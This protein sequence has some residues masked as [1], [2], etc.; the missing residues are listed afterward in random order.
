MG[1]GLKNK[2][3]IFF[4]LIAILM[5][6]VFFVA[7]SPRPTSD[8]IDT[9]KIQEFRI[10]S[11]DNF[12]RLVR[13]AYIPATLRTSSYL[14]LEVLSDYQKSTGERFA[15]HDELE[16]KFAEVMTSGSLNGVP[17]EKMSG[18]AL[19][20]RLEDI[21]NLSRSTLLINSRFSYSD[22]DVSLYQNNDTGAFQIGVNATI[23]FFAGDTLAKWDK[24][25]TYSIVFNSEDIEDPLYSVG[26][27]NITKDG[28]VYTN[29]FRKTNATVWNLT[30]VFRQIDERLYYHNPKAPSILARFTNQSA[31]S[32]CCGVESFINP[33]AMNHPNITGQTGK[34]FIDWC[35]LDPGC[36]E[37]RTFN[38]TC[39]T[40]NQRNQKF[41]N[42]RL[43]IDSILWYNLTNYTN[44]DASCTV[45]T[46]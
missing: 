31:P 30:T 36:N 42:F 13:H 44:P 1:I 18:K 45:L 4:T 23:S 26:S 33:N 21:S 16:E 24:A 38:I 3:G 39:I 8:A 7:L 46:S 43:D 9:M 15:D 28:T 25:E 41:Y 14:A 19:K 32:E 6:S 20:T 35:F 29:R 40:K 11:S 5:V 17:V 22:Y 34:S 10:D 2:K 12:V 37:S 27:R